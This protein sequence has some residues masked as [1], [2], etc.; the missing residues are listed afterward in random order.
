MLN[1]KIN[2]AKVGDAFP[3]TGGSL[4]Q[5]Q[6]QQSVLL[7]LKERIASGEK[8]SAKDQKLV[9]QLEK[10]LSSYR[11]YADVRD[12]LLNNK[13]SSFALGS[14]TVAAICYVNAHTS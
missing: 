8:L 4:E 11:N 6:N 12:L 10:A 13:M 3:Y 9:G 1:D 14:S 2:D 5:V 7:N